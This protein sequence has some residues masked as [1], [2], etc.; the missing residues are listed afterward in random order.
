MTLQCSSFSSP[1]YPL[2]FS[3]VFYKASLRKHFVST[4]STLVWSKINFS[5]LQ[6]VLETVEQ[7][8]QK[9]SSFSTTAASINSQSNASKEKKRQVS[10]SSSSSSFSLFFQAWECNMKHWPLC[11][12]SEP[13]SVPP[14]SCHTQWKP[15]WLAHVHPH[16]HTFAYV[17][18]VGNVISY[19]AWRCVGSC[20]CVWG[21]LLL[22]LTP[23]KQRAQT[24]LSFYFGTHTGGGGWVAVP[25][26]VGVFV[27]CEMME[28]ETI[29]R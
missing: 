28:K 23:S 21:G 9:R 27:A 20:E 16:T 24:N 4:I 8:P 17:E 10:S 19:A 18:W 7:R 6:A 25:L 14:P 13:P 12:Y 2:W 15:I 11:F 1:S 5:Y 29:W 26:W 22:R 3:D